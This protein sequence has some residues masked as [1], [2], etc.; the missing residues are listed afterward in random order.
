MKKLN[1]LKISASPTLAINTL[2][3]EKRAL[4]ETV[5]NLSA[6]EPMISVAPQISKAITQALRDDKTHYPPPPGIPELRKAVSDWMNDWYDC[7]FTVANT[8]V[9]PG[10]KFGLFALFQMLL[11]KGDEVLVVAPYWVSYTTII[12]FFFGTLK[13]VESTESSGWKVTATD[14]EKKITSKTKF[15]ILNNGGNPTGSLYSEKELR[16]IVACAT[17]HN[18]L[19][20]SDEVYSTLVYDKNKF[21]SCGQFTEYRD[22]VIIIHSCSKSFAMTGLR[23]GFVFANTEIIQALSGLV[24][25]S[26][27]G[28]ISIVQ[29]GALAGFQNAQKIIPKINT[30]MQ[31]RRDVFIK[32]FN[33]SFQTK[34]KPPASGLYAFVSLKTL[35]WKDT[36]SEEF[37]KSAMQYANVAI[38]PGSAFGKDGYVRFSFG[39][40]PPVLVAG[41][42]A[43]AKWLRSKKS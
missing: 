29:W 40:K 1:I 25:Q 32:K 42:T 26:T 27:S 20:I 31:K 10:G 39:E 14:I 35:G 8:L 9:V 38:V 13:I 19:V 24:S 12:E 15:I 30:E 6:G 41:I 37:C 11:K 34:F 3:M 7:D 28:T 36:N 33:T 23:V 17:K 5:F 16:Q 2:A 22:N 4:G 21:I 18:L 43:L